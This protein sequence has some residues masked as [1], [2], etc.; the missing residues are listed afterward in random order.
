MLIMDPK[1]KSDLDPIRITKRILKFV[2][3]P[4]AIF[5][6]MIGIYLEVLR[7]PEE[8]DQVIRL[9]AAA[10][11]GV[12]RQGLLKKLRRYGL[13]ATEEAE[14]RFAERTPA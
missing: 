7:N 2:L 13:G 10:A 11:L 1:K 4:A 14:A 5:S 6:G 12:S 9:G 8:L 3:V